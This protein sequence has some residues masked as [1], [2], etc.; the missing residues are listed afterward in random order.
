[1]HQR[2]LESDLIHCQPSSIV[3][4]DLA[5]R[6]NAVRQHPCPDYARGSF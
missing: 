1:M 4:A 5:V 2:A 3:F 6:E